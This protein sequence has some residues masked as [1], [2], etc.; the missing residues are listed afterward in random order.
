[1]SFLPPDKL[2]AQVDDSELCK[3]IPPD[4]WC[5]EYFDGSFICYLQYGCFHESSVYACENIVL[6]CSIWTPSPNFLD[7]HL[8]KHTHVLVLFWDDCK[9][10]NLRLEYK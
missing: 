6:S 4:Y 5:T 1:M 7:P 3:F 8:N 2:L 10:V 9:S